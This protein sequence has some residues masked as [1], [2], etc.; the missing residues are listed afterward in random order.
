MAIRLRL[1]LLYSAILAL[2]LTTLSVTVYTA[3]SRALA[4][5]LERGLVSRTHRTVGPRELY[6]SGESRLFPPSPEAE[7]AF[8]GAYAVQLR[9]PEG[10]VIGDA[11][12]RCGVVLPLSD[13]GLQALRNGE[14]WLETTSVEGERV[15]VH[16]A[17]VVVRGEVREI[18]QVACTLAQ[19]HQHLLA[20][21]RDLLIASSLAT[22]AAFG[23]G[24]VLAGTTL[25]P[26]ER[27]TQTAQAIGDDHDFRRRVQYTGPDDEVGRLATTFNAM[28]GELQDAHFEVEES[29][30]MLR[31]FVADV[32]HE[33]RTPLT[34]IRG[35]LALL[36]KRPV[37]AE[38][39]DDILG[40]TVD[41]TERLIRLVNDLLQLARAQAGREIQRAPV[42]VKPLIEDA[43]RRARLL[44]PSRAVI[45]DPLLDIAVLGDRDAL[46]Q[47]LL[48]LL[49]NA[50]THA[51]GTISIEAQI[52]SEAIEG[53]S[54]RKVEIRVRDS[55]P[56]MAPGVLSHIF[57][58][59]YRGDR[60]EGLGLGLGLPIAKALVEAQD[61]TLAV[62]SKPGQGSVF[63]VALPLARST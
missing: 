45:C 48:I 61:G 25:R 41:E 24:W 35:N 7:P 62:V 15:L 9:D 4:A 56:G 10:E 11:E 46:E 38:E 47:V 21:R 32:S 22:A 55:G 50:L 34:T 49:N 31:D 39:R 36:R 29:L 30:E 26:I 42:S 53:G 18:V 23:I 60:G 40:D 19:Y 17:P 63:T 1:T 43:C 16:S 57:E 5:L 58:R 14:S 59:F 6:L 12:I 44:D 27:I 54:G 8:T 2:V 20:L 3:Q 37:P 51:E 33:L 52:G 28:L 13:A